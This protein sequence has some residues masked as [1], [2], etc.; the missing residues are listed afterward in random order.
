MIP[1]RLPDPPPILG[2]PVPGSSQPPQPPRPPLSPLRRWSRVLVWVAFG[3]VLTL[4]FFTPTERVPRS[5]GPFPQ[6]VPINEG[7]PFGGG[8]RGQWGRRPPT[9]VNPPVT[10]IPGDLWRISIE[11][12]SGD[13]AKLGSYF[14]SRRGG[15]GDAR[16]EVSATI[17]EGGVV[18]TNVT[19]HSKGSAGSFRS[20]DDKPALT[21]NFSKNASG[22]RFH[23]FSKVSLNNS[24]QDPTYVCEALCREIFG[25]AGVPAPQADHA[26]VLLNGRDLGLYVVVEGWGK[27]FLGK[28]FK[29]VDGNLYDGG[30]VRDIDSGL[31]INSGDDGEGRE[32]LKRLLATASDPDVEKRWTRLN[33]ILDVNRFA[34]LLALE[35]MLCHWDGYALNRNNYRVFHDRATGRLVFMPHGLD[36]MFG[37]DGRMS[38]NSSI[39]PLMRGQIASAFVSVPEGRRLYFDRIAQLQA[40]VFLEDRMTNRVHELARKIHSTIAAYGTELGVEHDALIADLCERITA[41]VA[42]VSEQLK[43]PREPAEFGADGTFATTGWKMR[44]NPQGGGAVPHFERSEVDGITL[45]RI[46]LTKGRGSGSWRNRVRLGAGQYRFEGRAKTSGVGGKGAFCLRIS[47][48]R[49]GYVKGTDGEW[50]PLNYSFGI[51]GGVGEIELV[52]EFESEVGEIAFDEGSLRL[53]K[54]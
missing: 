12:S 29:D 24:V 44:V 6:G 28:H 30:F 51:G 32:D 50:T 16:P 27:P 15:G 31:E 11:I 20:I 14:W 19:V 45:L 35:V 4:R 41:R 39:E 3:L 23:G 38:P 8:E 42:S 47:G 43:A 17:R 33:A 40:N 48:D 5:R 9:R 7:N 10:V 2:T 1:P 18:Y 52:C 46:Q 49:R 36:Q 21:L 34:S 22:Q 13:M 25:A 37:T 53:V 54:E 26:T